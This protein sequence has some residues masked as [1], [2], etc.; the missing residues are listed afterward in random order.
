VPLAPGSRVGP[1]SI[2]AQIGAGGM[3]EVYRARDA[4]LGREVAI[5]VLP[6]QFADDPERLARFERE[7]QL[8][9]SLNHPNI[10][11]MHGLEESGGVHAL[12]MELVE[13]DT[14]A[15]RLARGALPIDETLAIASQIADALQ[16][17]HDRGVVHRDLKPA[18]VKLT[19]DGTAKVLDFGLAK[20]MGADDGVESNPNATHSPTITAG[21]TRAGV[22][23][24][25]AA[26][27]SPEQARGKSVDKR[28]D[29]WAF[30][31]LVYECLTGRMAFSGETV[32]DT[33]SLILQREPDWSALPSNTPAG[34]RRLLARCLEKDARKRLRDIGDARLDLEDTRP[35]ETTGARRMSHGR[36]MAV[37][38]GVL[39][40]G[41]AIGY[42]SR[43]A[44]PFAN[45]TSSDTAGTI[46]V[47][48]TPPAGVHV[49]SFMLS[50]DG[51]HIIFKGQPASDPDTPYLFTRSLD[52]FAPKRIEG[53]AGVGDFACSCD[54]RWIAV[55]VPEGNERKLARVAIDGS[56]PPVTRAFVK[57]GW[58]SPCW[59]PN[60]D[61]IMPTSYQKAYVRIPSEERKEPVERPIHRGSVTGQITLSKS[62]PD[63]SGILARLQNWAPD[64]FHIGTALLDLKTDSV[65]VLVAEGGGGEG[66]SGEYA[67]TGH[68]VF[69]RHDVLFAAPF[70]LRT[71]SVSGAAVALFT[72]L[73]TRASWS[74]GRFYLSDNGTLM[75]PPGTRT[76]SQR[77]LVW[78]NENGGVTALTHDPLTLEELC[79]SKDGKRIVVA[80]ANARGL[81]ELWIGEGDAPQLRPLL[82][83]PGADC[84]EPC[85]SPDGERIAFVRRGD[86]VGDGIYTLDVDRSAQ[87]VRIAAADSTHPDYDPWGW[88]GDGRFVL[89]T[90]SSKQDGTMSLVAIRADGSN[91]AVIDV[92]RGN[93]L[94]GPVTSPDDRYILWTSEVSGRA[95]LYI[96]EFDGVARRGAP[97]RVSSE[98]IYMP[99]SSVFLSRFGWRGPREV[100]Y[101]DPRMRLMSTRIN[102]APLSAEAPVMIA[103]LRALQIEPLR[104][105]VLPSGRILA[106]QNGPDENETAHYNLVINWYD[107]LRAKMKAQ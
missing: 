63:G 43:G 47:S 17:A 1:Y 62:L 64:G 22:I 85:W 66:G 15:D 100:C 14:L 72:G 106:V 10:A 5:K 98:G 55:V 24:G 32:S 95:E 50:P 49:E 91:M 48:V 7:A 105:N 30:G 59:L 83:I 44:R 12:V 88:S 107:E 29:I 42:L 36:A 102:T 53:T 25:T 13:G 94:V 87:P 8:L 40:V 4:R 96:A 80:Q 52:D 61:I 67:S 86:N 18:N 37:A 11:H 71:R 27:M 31:C 45:I 35:A 3:G 75:Y 93:V 73:Q 19:A 97:H 21:H 56:S 77:R 6:E 20:A 39:V 41:T 23:L 89:A 38:A 69:A 70:D 79:A 57:E 81:Y 92:G 82:A 74:E 60:G 34:T 76:G 103:D 46:C 54:G 33:I 58:G 65:R 99:P 101:V 2:V 26:Y 28:T 104:I 90:Q 78:I 84:A 51:K 9:A 16:Y 68:L